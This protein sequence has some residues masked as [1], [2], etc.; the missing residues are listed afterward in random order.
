MGFFGKLFQKKN[1][2]EDKGLPSFSPLPAPIIPSPGRET[3][4][5]KYILEKNVGNLQQVRPPRK[6]YLWQGRNANNEP[7]SIGIVS[8]GEENR[9]WLEDRL[10]QIKIEEWKDIKTQGSLRKIG[11][12]LSVLIFG[13][14][15]AE[16]Y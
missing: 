3:P 4:V 16:K 10:G 1:E 12:Q 13:T 11:D 15:V 9:Q 7:C 6:A 2:K 8:P 5:G 14:L